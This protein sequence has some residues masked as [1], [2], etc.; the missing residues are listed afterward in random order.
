[1]IIDKHK[2]YN[3]PACYLMAYHTEYHIK[4]DISIIKGLGKK[5]SADEYLLRYYEKC[6]EKFPCFKKKNDEN[7][8]NELEANLY[9]I[10]E[11]LGDESFSETNFP[12]CYTEELYECIMQYLEDGDAHVK[13]QSLTKEQ[14]KE[15]LRR[16]KLKVS[17][18]KD[19]LLE[20][21]FENI[22]IEKLE[23]DTNLPKFYK[24]SK[25]GKDFLK[26][27]YFWSFYLKIT[28]IDGDPLN[29]F[30]T[31][32]QYIHL[33]DEMTNENRYEIILNYLN[34]CKFA[35]LNEYLISLFAYARVYNL[36]DDFENLLKIA[37]K[38]SLI[39][40]NH[41]ID[42]DCPV[43][44]LNIRNDEYVEEFKVY[45]ITGDYRRILDLFCTLIDSNPQFDKLEDFI[46]ESYA[47]IKEFLPK[48]TEKSS[49]CYLVK[50]LDEDERKHVFSNKDSDDEKLNEI[51][52]EE[53]ITYNQEEPLN[54]QNKGGTLNTQ[55]KV[56]Y[57]EWLEAFIYY[58]SEEGPG[59]FDVQF[60]KEQMG[61]DFF[62]ESEKDDLKVNEFLIKTDELV[63]Q[64][65]TK[66]EIE[67][68][69]KEYIDFL[70]TEGKKEI[71]RL[72][73]EYDRREA[74]SNKMWKNNLKAQQLEKEGK[75]DE[76]VKLY[77]E[78]LKLEED[79]DYESIAGLAYH[80]LAINYRK[81]RDYP[82]EIKLCERYLQIVPRGYPNEK[83][84][85]WFEK[86]LEKAKK[87]KKTYYY[88][89][90]D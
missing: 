58:R 36:K 48:L 73:D 27:K 23:R 65:L 56:L 6:Y 74:I 29:Y 24:V 81:R 70:N 83:D 72:T 76:A 15:L 40:I 28:G 18:R 49:I 19:E 78:N 2:L 47:E 14:L 25:K 17:G 41:W 54:A 90:T 39:Y 43:L 42:D 59:D 57:D 82:K 35:N 22:P 89:F 5:S 71:K 4:D 55:E 52:V 1:M 44:I 31:P 32:N 51:E 9:R 84:I 53:E 87:L 80:R 67:L 12:T 33:K 66:E 21:C 16:N 69:L 30:F 38:I 13:V 3:Y 8:K 62:Y 50:Y 68:E 77:E 26:D 63:S 64:N 85:E 34:N 88:L 37:I 10:L 20:R 86:R 79:L 11:E 7:H 61:L 46:K 60:I 75:I 45:S